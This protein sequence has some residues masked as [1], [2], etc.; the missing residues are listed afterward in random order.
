VGFP[1][2]VTKNCE[3]TIGK[4]REREGNRTG[5]RRENIEEIRIRTK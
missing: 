4:E 1:Q 3:L 5:E 2:A